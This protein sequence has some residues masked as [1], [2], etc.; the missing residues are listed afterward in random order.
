MDEE[1]TRSFTSVF[2]FFREGEHTRSSYLNCCRCYIGNLQLELKFFHSHCPFFNV[3]LTIHSLC[4]TCLIKNE[5]H[6]QG[7][8]RS[9]LLEQANAVLWHTY[10]CSTIN[11]YTHTHKSFAGYPPYTPPLLVVAVCVYAQTSLLSPS[12]SACNHSAE[13]NFIVGSIF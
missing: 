7:N 3:C 6:W 8:R 5:M 10:S 9:L 2:F 1:T 13:I 12:K 4:P 11:K